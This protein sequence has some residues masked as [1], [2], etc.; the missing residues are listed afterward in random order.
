[1]QPEPFDPVI[2]NDNESYAKDRIT[3]LVWHRVF[4]RTLYIDT[5]RSGVV[6]HSN[7]LRYFELGRGTLMRDA[8]RP[9][10]QIEQSGFFY[11][12]VETKI[13]FYKALFYDDPMWIYSRPDKLEK[14]KIQFQ[15]IIVHAKTKEIIC[16]GRTLHCAQ[17]VDGKVVGVDTKTANICKNFYK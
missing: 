3:G 2:F 15:Y 4:N 10:K 14:V 13:R 6:Y 9:Y 8:S 17:T 16:K 1:M 12:V 7:Y 11:P 5:D